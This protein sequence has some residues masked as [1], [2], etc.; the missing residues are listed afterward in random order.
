MFIIYQMWRNERGGGEAEA[1][2]EPAVGRDLNA[3]PLHSL[4]NTQ[5][6][7]SIYLKMGSRQPEPAQNKTSSEQ[8][9]LVLAKQQT[10]KDE[11]F[12]ENW[13]GGSLSQKF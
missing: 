1:V 9:L 12:M 2:P 7:I 11:Q 8:M 13:L 6:L 5:R 10:G 3:V 4:H